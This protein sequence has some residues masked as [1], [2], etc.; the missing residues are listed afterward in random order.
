MKKSELTH[1]IEETYAETLSS[2]SSEDAAKRLLGISDGKK[3]MTNEEI[4]A[5]CLHASLEMN[6][7]FISA[8]CCKLLADD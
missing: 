5:N 2:F 3:P 1:I 4:Y 6:K 8:L 7:V